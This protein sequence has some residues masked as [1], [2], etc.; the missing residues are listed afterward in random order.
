MKQCLFSISGFQERPEG[1]KGSFLGKVTSLSQVNIAKT[2]LAV[3]IEMMMKVEL[4]MIEMMTPV[5]LRWLVP[6]PTRPRTRRR[7]SKLKE[8][9]DT[10]AA[11]P[12]S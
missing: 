8:L 4:K 6:K 12:C 1:K 7:H 5:Q 10:I 11:S 3:V 2:M 9:K